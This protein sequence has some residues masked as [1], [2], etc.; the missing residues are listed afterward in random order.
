MILVSVRRHD[1]NCSEIKSCHHLTISNIQAKH[2][3]TVKAKKKKWFIWLWL[4]LDSSQSIMGIWWYWNQTSIVYH[5]CQ[6]ASLCGICAVCVWARSLL[7]SSCICMPLKKLFLFL[8]QIWWEGECVQLYPAE[9]ISDQGHQKSAVGTV[10]WH[11]VMAQSYHAKK[12]PCQN[13]QV[14]WLNFFLLL[15]FP[16][17]AVSF[18]TSLHV[19]CSRYSHEHIEILTVNGELL[20]FRQREGPFYPTLRLLHKCK[21]F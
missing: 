3:S 15:M 8:F 5:Q 6:C 11:R 1:A 4:K 18:F 12:G 21:I 19:C 20:F 9:N 2:I 7:I 10:S 13:S 16:S 17:I 14:V